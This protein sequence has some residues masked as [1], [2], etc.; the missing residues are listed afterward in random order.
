MY[1]LISWV[2]N[3]V[4]IKISLVIEL[5]L[6]SFEPNTLSAGFGMS[7]WNQITSVRIGKRPSKGNWICIFSNSN[8]LSKS[9]N[10]HE[11][12]LFLQIL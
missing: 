3:S 1:V 11:N 7:Q 2:V 5:Y 10:W 8:R 4:V 9:G 6:E 12:V